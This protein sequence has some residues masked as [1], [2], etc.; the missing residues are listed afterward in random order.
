MISTFTEPTTVQTDIQTK[1]ARNNGQSEQCCYSDTLPTFVRQAYFEISYSK[2]LRGPCNSTLRTYSSN[3]PLWSIC[4]YTCGRSQQELKVSFHHFQSAHSLILCCQTSCSARA[5]YVLAPKI[6][7]ICLTPVKR[8]C[9]A[10]NQR[11]PS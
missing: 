5:E 1:H 10:T 11:M 8:I 9:L 3:S 6:A 4:V 2:V 7:C